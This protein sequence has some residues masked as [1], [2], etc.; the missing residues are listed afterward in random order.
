LTIHR[1]RLR[2]RAL[3]QFAKVLM[4]GTGLLWLAGMANGAR[5]F[6]PPYWKI[7]LCQQRAKPNCSDLQSSAARPAI[8]ADS[9]PN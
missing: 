5:F 3:L 4:E 9:G 6:A 8:I 7:K 2:H 1:E